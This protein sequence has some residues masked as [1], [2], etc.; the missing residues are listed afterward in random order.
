MLR[1]VIEYLRRKN[2][3]TVEDLVVEICSGNMYYKYIS[4]AKNLSSKNLKL[5]KER[6]DVNDSVKEDL[7]QFFALIENEKIDMKGLHLNYTK[8]EAIRIIKQV[9]Q[10]D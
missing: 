5:I 3:I 7:Q 2:K 9:F 4:G 1:K 10:M 6:I 8:E